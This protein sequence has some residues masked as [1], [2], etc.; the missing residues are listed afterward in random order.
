MTACAA[1]EKPGDVEFRLR[2]PDGTVRVFSRRGELQYDSDNK[3]IRMVGTSQDIT[4]RR[5]AEAALR[6]SEERFQAMANGIQ[7]LAWM[8]DADGSIFWYNQRWYDYTGTTLEQ[9]RGWTW[10]KIHDPAFLPI[11]LDR[12]K[13]S[14]RHGTPLD[15]EFPLRGADGQFPHVP[16][17]RHAGQEFGRT[18]GPL[19]GNEYRYQR[20]Q[21]G[22]KN[23]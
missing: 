2:L 9:T 12:W 10:E 6:E 21:E 13:R 14:D 11:V 15:M 5:Q 23:N 22:Q 1:G 7:Q 20:P 18:R 16:Y 8:A 17:P 19:A 3:P 4:E